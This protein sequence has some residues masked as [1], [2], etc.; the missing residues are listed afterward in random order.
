LVPSARHELK[1][2]TLHLLFFQ[3]NP[4]AGFNTVPKQEIGVTPTDFA[5][6]VG[7]WS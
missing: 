7:T 2:P 1:I 6:H 4:A 3:N 5:G